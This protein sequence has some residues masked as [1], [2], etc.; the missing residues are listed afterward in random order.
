[1]RSQQEKGHVIPA[2]AGNQHLKEEAAS[3]HFFSG[4]GPGLRR[5]DDQVGTDDNAGIA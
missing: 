4:L 1:M 2:K 5:D 3:R